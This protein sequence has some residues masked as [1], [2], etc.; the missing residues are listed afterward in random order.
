[1]QNDCRTAGVRD[2]VVKSRSGSSGK[3]V[4]AL[5]TGTQFAASISMIAITGVVQRQL[6]FV[7]SRDLGYDRDD[8]IIMGIFNHQHIKDKVYEEVKTAMLAH[9]GG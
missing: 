5:W 1:M 3:E 7:G 8:M 6:D 9:P 2:R 4:R